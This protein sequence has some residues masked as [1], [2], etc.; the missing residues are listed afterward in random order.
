MKREEV[1]KE[2]TPTEGE[3]LKAGWRIKVGFAL[4][5]TSIGW[6]VLVPAMPFLGFTGI[7]IAAFSGVMLVVAEL[8]I[9]A[10]VAISGKQGFAYIKA[11][12][13][14]VF[15]A[16]GPPQK[17]SLTRYKIGLVLFVLMLLLGWAGPYFGEYLPGYTEQTMIYAIVGDVVLLVSLFVLGG[18]FWDKLRALFIHRAHAVIPDKP[19]KAEAAK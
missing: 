15:K 4:F 8:M 7:Q 18:E 9:V 3:E 2:V 10:G 11:K 13:F 19:A 5:I 1:V 12:V 17:V 14:G 16:Y 6:P